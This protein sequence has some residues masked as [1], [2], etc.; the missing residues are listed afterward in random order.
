VFALRKLDEAVEVFQNAYKLLRTR[1]MNMSAALHAAVS[2]LTA[3]L[4]EARQSAMRPTPRA[5]RAPSADLAAVLDKLRVEYG[6]RWRVKDL[7]QLVGISVP[8]FFR[9]FNQMTGSSPMDWLRRH[10]VNEAKRRLSETRGHIGDIAN[11]VGYSDPLYFSRDFKKVVGVSP[12][13][14]R[15][16]EQ[17]KV[18]SG[19]SG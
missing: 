17:A 13:R 5:E 9:R 14:Y 18:V 12:R 4:F 10:R 15:E 3:I 8:Q 7:A 1:P 6:R 2:S 19:R 11:Q 16:T